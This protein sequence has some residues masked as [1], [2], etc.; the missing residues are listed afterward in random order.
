M[1]SSNDPHLGPSRTFSKATD[2]TSTFLSANA[3]GFPGYLKLLDPSRPNLNLFRKAKITAAFLP[4]G[5]EP[6]TT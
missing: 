4:D 6:I 3:F 5:F 2:T 1:R